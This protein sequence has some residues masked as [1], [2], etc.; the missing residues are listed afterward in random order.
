[1]DG[2][3]RLHRHLRMA[4]LPTRCSDAGQQDQGA[5]M[6]SG[7][8][9][10]CGLRPLGRRLE[11]RG[12]CCAVHELPRLHRVVAR[13][14]EDIFARRCR[15]TVLGNPR[16]C[17]WCLGDALETRRQH[18]DADVRPDAGNAASGLS[19]AG[20]RDVWRRAGSRADR[21]RHL[22]HAADGALYDSG[23]A[24]SAQ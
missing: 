14:D 16:P 1:M 18:F 5:A 13:V 9:W 17:A 15:G 19:R 11:T 12:W 24:N 20:G 22:R 23:A 7:G 3:N 2:G 4:R 8:R 6:D 21:N 10:F